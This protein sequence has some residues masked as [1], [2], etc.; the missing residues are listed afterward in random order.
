MLIPDRKLVYKQYFKWLFKSSKYIKALQST[1]N[2]V[3]DGQAMRYANFVQVRL[4]LLPI[5]EQ[6]SIACYL[7]KKCEAIDELVARHEQTI[8]KL[9]E[10]KTATIA[11]VVTGKVDVRESI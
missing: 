5:S 2:L 8:E 4:P 9:K 6:K 10:L 7:D 3:R 11:D 1:S